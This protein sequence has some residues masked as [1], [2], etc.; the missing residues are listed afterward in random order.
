MVQLSLQAGTGTVAVPKRRALI[1]KVLIPCTRT[2]QRTNGTHFTV[3]AVEGENLRLLAKN[4]VEFPEKWTEIADAIAGG[5]LEVAEP[6]AA[7]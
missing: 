7:K 3:L 2:G 1:G 4:G 5:W 6:T